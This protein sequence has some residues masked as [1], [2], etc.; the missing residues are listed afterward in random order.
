MSS[1]RSNTL[2]AKAGQK[3]PAK[4]QTKSSLFTPK[5]KPF[6]R[7]ELVQMFRSLASMLKAQINTSDALKYYAHGH[8][9]KE[10]VSALT[11]IHDD[12][13]KGVPIHTAFKKSKR[14]DDMIVG[15]IQA[16]GDAGQ[17]DTA[18]AELGKRIKTEIVFR[19]KIRKLIMMPCIVI[20]VLFGAFIYSQVKIVPKVKEMMGSIEPEGFVALSFKLSHLMQQIWP[21]MVAIILAIVIAFWR[22][23]KL[24]NAATNLAMAR[25]RVIRLMIMSLRQMSVLATIQLL[26]TNGINLA[27]SLRVAANS[28]KKTPFYGELRKAADMYEKSGVPL[29]SAFD[30]YTSVDPQVVHM[31]AIGEKSSSLGTQFGLLAEM[32]EEDAEQLM[33]DFSQLVS[34]S[35]MMIAVLLIA[36]VFIGTFL[37]IFMM[38][39]QM[40]KNAM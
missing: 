13:N 30:K 8:P 1:T 24:R 7:K 14:F 20:P 38:G 37:P 19:K 2:A 5:T 15:L 33:D 27:K 12:L 29:S 10:L 18:F 34:F 21:Y 32:Y 25:F 3:T 23:L 17:L 6:A 9:N 11:Q 31:V 4:A 26:Y 22:S 39:P 36:A 35:V 16:G 28:V 40:M